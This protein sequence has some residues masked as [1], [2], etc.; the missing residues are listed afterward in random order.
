VDPD[1]AYHFEADPDPAYQFD[2]DPNP[3]PTLQYGRQNTG[4][5]KD[6]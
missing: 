6:I 4:S 5:F 1:P 2:A 3:V